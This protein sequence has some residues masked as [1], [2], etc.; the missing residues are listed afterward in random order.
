VPQELTGPSDVWAGYLKKLCEDGYAHIPQFLEPAL[1]K[2]IVLAVDAAF[3]EAPYGRNESTG[4]I[5]SASRSVGLG[6]DVDLLS[7][8]QL[9]DKNLNS[10]PL[11]PNLFGLLEKLLGRDYYLDRAVVRRA[12]GKCG[13][14]YFHKDQHG[15]VGLTVLLNDLGKDE[16]ATTAIPGRHLGTPPS[17]FTIRDIN[18]RHPEEVQMTGKAGDAYLFIRDID[19]SRAENLTDK[20][21]AQ[22]IFAFINKNTFPAAHSKQGITLED[23]ESVD[24]ALEHMLRPY[25]G[26]PLDAPKGFV[27]KYLY[28]G[29]YSSPGGGDYDIRNDLFRD[30]IYTMFYVRGKPL[31]SGPDALLPRNTTWLN[32]IKHVSFLQYITHLNWWLV[33]RNLLL[34]LLRRFKIGDAVVAILKKLRPAPS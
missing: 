4:E 33:F 8:I 14:F 32:E 26:E 13:R 1:L 21:N 24:P 9:R 5:E 2:D 29:G 34:K 31:R 12:R 19:H 30:F 16:G 11:N 6:S 15:D 10:V 17:L 28:G 18:P 23:L 22:L 25:D 3:V 20:A 27:E 7:I